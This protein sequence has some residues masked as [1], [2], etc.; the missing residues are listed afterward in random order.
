MW[1]KP[2]A[3]QVELLLFYFT[4]LLMQINVFLYQDAEFNSICISQLSERI[5]VTRSL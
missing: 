3:L 4:V 1:K 2:E 5:N